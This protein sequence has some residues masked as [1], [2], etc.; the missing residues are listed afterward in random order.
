MVQ[1]TSYAIEVS[2]AQSMW[3]AA[4]GLSQPLKRCFVGREREMAVLRA[5]LEDACGGDGRLCLLAGEPGIGKTR[6]VHEF[7]TYAGQHGAQVLLGR[8]YD[9]AGAP[10]FWPWLQVIRTYIA[11]R[12]PEHLRA[13]MGTGAAAIA[14]VFAEVRQALP[15]LPPLPALEA[16]QERFRFFDSLTT[17]LK[18]AAQRQP[19]LLV[20]DDLHWADTP[21][22]LL[23]Q[24]LAREM[25]QA[26]LCIVGTYRDVALDQ[27]HPL[28]HTL[29]ELVREPGHQRLCLQGLSQDEVACFLASTIGATPHEAVAAFLYRQ[30][31]GNPFFL[32]EVVRLLATSGTPVTRLT[33]HGRVPPACG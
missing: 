8:C 19:L 32:T 22:L 18:N 7:A 29:G 26:R 15:D 21:S 10:P 30:T 28:T 11:H 16:T 3:V 6:T 5:A 17:C 23:L 20:L 13:E 2:T 14:H 9:G 33:P 31:E 12:T 27:H 1:G 24:F 4:P 25:C